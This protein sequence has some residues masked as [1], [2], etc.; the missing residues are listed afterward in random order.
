MTDQPKKLNLTDQDKDLKIYVLT[1]QKGKMNV[2]IQEDTRIIMAYN[3]HDASNVA[4]GFY[5]NNEHLFIN[6]KAT[7]EV[8]KLMD[9]INFPQTQTREVR[10]IVAPP[11]PE[12][13]K[14]KEK[15]PQDFVNGMLLLSDQYVK[16]KKDKETVKKILNKI[17]IHGPK[18]NTK[19]KKGSS[20]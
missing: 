9:V 10:D 11:A 20:R 2:T 16:T 13:E 3:E 5:T 17:K 15:T 12:V 14:A 6:K 18:Q 19:S 7:M 8:K 1:I 4:Q